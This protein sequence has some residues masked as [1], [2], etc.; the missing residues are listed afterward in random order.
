MK[1]LIVDTLLAGHSPKQIALFGTKAIISVK[2]NLSN[3]I[4][5]LQGAKFFSRS[6]VLIRGVSQYDF[7]FFKVAHVS[8]LEEFHSMTLNLLK[9]NT[10]RFL[11]ELFQELIHLTILVIVSIAAT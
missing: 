7:K 9:S 8:S 10:V 2:I 1:P 5:H 6:C 3:M 4:T 11:Q